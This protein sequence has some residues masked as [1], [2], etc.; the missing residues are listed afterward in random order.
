MEVC[1]VMLPLSHRFV[2]L[3]C[4]SRTRS[5]QFQ[6]RQRRERRGVRQQPHRG[7]DQPSK[8]EE[9]SRCIV[10]FKCDKILW[11]SLTQWSSQFPVTR[12]VPKVR[13]GFM[14]DPVYETTPRCPSVTVNPIAKG[15]MKRESGLFS[16]VTPKTTR[17]R[18]NPRKNSKPSPWNSLTCAFNDVWPSEPVPGTPLT[19][20]CNVATPAAAPA[21]CAMM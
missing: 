3:F 9:I 8:P 10:R 11:R 12:A 18:T 5:C 20:T 1:Q 13:A 4:T 7:L 19:R 6:E 21:H 2:W 15:A 16:S 14:L 17:T